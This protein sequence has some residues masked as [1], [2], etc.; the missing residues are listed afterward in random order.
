MEQ[1]RERTSCGGCCLGLPSVSTPRATTVPAACVCSA[2]RA[3]SLSGSWPS[4]Q[5][6]G[7]N[8][9]NSTAGRALASGLVVSFPLAPFQV[10]GPG[11]TVRQSYNEGTNV[12]LRGLAPRRLE[13]AVAFRPEEQRRF[14]PYCL[15]PLA[16]GSWCADD[17][18]FFVPDLGANW[19]RR[20]TTRYP[21]RLRVGRPRAE[22]VAEMA[23]SRLP[24]PPIAPDWTFRR[25]LD[26]AAA[27]Q[28]CN[29][30]SGAYS[31][32]R[33]YGSRPP[34]AGEPSALSLSTIWV[35]QHWPNTLAQKLNIQE[36]D[37]TKSSDAENGALSGYEHIITLEETPQ[38][39]SRWER[40]MRLKT[41]SVWPGQSSRRQTRDLRKLANK[42]KTNHELALSLWKTR[43]HDAQFLATAPYQSQSPVRGA[44]EWEGEW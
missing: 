8:S 14:V 27:N 31:D 38:T 3:R 28:C 2:P 11:P 16:F 37:E 7:L 19:S 18:V 23:R 29:L 33:V 36:V 24:A 17:D 25:P 13:G 41:P 26:G 21:R 1:C 22:V 43:Q 5:R 6:P 10:V 12:L 34:G 9:F 4:D 42:I 20:T 15:F 32:F 44:Y 40:G 39:T 35:G 30:T